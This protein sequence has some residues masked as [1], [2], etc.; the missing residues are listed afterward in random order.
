MAA[1]SKS[2]TRK[3]GMGG[4]S[5]SPGSRPAGCAAFVTGDLSQTANVVL[6]GTLSHLI[7]LAGHYAHMS[8]SYFTL[9]SVQHVL[10]WSFAFQIW[11]L[12]NYV[13]SPSPL[14]VYCFGLSLPPFFL[15]PNDGPRR[16]AN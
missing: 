8:S 1:A 3:R 15:V 11:S 14:P 2:D 9:F 5:I 4:A 7:W 10:L 16:A 12:F 6:K 13:S